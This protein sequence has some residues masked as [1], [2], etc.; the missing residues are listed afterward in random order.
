MNQK[1]NRPT[2]RICL[3]SGPRNVSTALMYAFSQRSDTQVVDEPLYGHYLRVSEAKHPGYLEVLSKMNTDGSQ[4]VDEIILGP[5]K[6]PVLFMKQ[7]AHHLV[8][9]NLDFLSETINVLL[10]RDPFDVLRSLINQIPNPV[11]HD[12]GLRI[13]VDLLNTF[14]KLGQNLLVID[15]I[16]LLTDPSTI[17]SKLCQKIDISFQDQMLSWPKGGRP[18]DGVWA[19]YWYNNVHQSMG[20]KPYIPKTEPFP[21]HLEKLLAECK[22]LY[23]TLRF[24]AIT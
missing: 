1:T 10:I 15:S 9:I 24:H 6:Q 20:F 22:P 17:L 8:D 12:T 4:V 21:P 18:E 23:K 3:W 5:S 2:H 7:M 16:D 14:R 13:Q 19:P 11:L